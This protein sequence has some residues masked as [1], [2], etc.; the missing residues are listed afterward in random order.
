[1]SIRGNN[2]GFVKSKWRVGRKVG[3]TVYA[4][5]NK[6]PSD[7]DTLIGVFDSKELAEEAV[8]SHNNSLKKI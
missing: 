6:V 2:I 8:K 4:Q 3:R 1:M 5:I 7:E